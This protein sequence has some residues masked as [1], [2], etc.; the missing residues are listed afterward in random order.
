MIRTPAVASPDLLAPRPT[1]R[2]EVRRAILREARGLL[3]EKG[4]RLPLREVADAAGV[5]LG[6][7][8]RHIGRKGALI[9]TVM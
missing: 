6:L 1:G 2:A 5:N 3:S 9:D 7:I 8:H 4:P